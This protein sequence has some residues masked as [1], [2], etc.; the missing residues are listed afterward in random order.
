MLYEVITDNRLIIGVLYLIDHIFF[1]FAIGIN[2]YLQK[3]AEPEDIAPS[4]SVG[5]AINHLT[6][7][8]VPVIGGLLW[9]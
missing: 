7:V 9:A 1:N 8:I 3:I 4:T 5:F 6:A 2:T